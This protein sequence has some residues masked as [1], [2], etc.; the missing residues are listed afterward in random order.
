[1]TIDLSSILYLNKLSMPTT[2]AKNI[3]WEHRVALRSMTDAHFL[4]F[5]DGD[6]A[7]RSVEVFKTTLQDAAPS[8]DAPPLDFFENVGIS[9]NRFCLLGTLEELR[10]HRGDDSFKNGL[11]RDTIS[12]ERESMGLSENICTRDISRSLA[13]E[14][15][16]GFMDMPVEKPPDFDQ[17]DSSPLDDFSNLLKESHIENPKFSE[18]KKPRHN[19]TAG[20]C[21]AKRSNSLAGSLPS[22]LAKR[23]GSMPRIGSKR[24]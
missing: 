8:T 24:L 18:D 12:E 20:I 7:L 6:M 17:F 19:S 16:P 23:S 9:D 5:D 1:M 10:E 13:G 4:D 15:P 22:P 3:H 21:Y 11:Q 2:Q 14:H